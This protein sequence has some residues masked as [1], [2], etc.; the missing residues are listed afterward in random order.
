METDWYIKFGE[1]LQGRMSNEE[2]LAFEAELSSNEEM[3]SAFRIYRRIEMEMGSQSQHGDQENDLRRSLE[4]F[5][6]KYFNSET[7]HLTKTVSIFSK[8]YVRAA[9]AIAAGL[10]VL[11][12]AFAVL[13]Q[14]K[15]NIN[16]L[17]ENY[18]NAHLSQLGQ[19]MNA[20]SDSLQL[21]IAAYN[22]GE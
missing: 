12:V 9:M 10:V 7:Q 21:G 8:K 11:L 13:Y 14:P 19:T 6:A 4:T 16:L 18:I 2:K 1:Y 3:E 22:N 20:T 17:A 5:N 15:Q